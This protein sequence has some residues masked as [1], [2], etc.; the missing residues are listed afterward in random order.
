LAKTLVARLQGQQKVL[1]PISKA[2]AQIAT[3]RY[4]A[5]FGALEKTKILISLVGHEVFESANGKVKWRL[6]KQ[7]RYNSLYAVRCGKGKR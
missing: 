4:G 5:E 6:A 1:L 2:I 7:R 3:D